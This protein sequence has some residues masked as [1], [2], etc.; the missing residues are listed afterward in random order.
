M[1]VPSPLDLVS[2]ITLDEVTVIIPRKYNNMLI[3][4]YVLKAQLL[5]EA[6]I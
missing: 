1:K 3:E 4:I 6:L 5:Y 2:I